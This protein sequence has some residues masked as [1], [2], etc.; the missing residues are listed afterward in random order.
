MKAEAVQAWFWAE[1]RRQ[2]E[3]ESRISHQMV[4]GVD[5]KLRKK[6]RE[7]VIYC[8]T[9]R[10]AC[11]LLTV[12]RFGGDLP[13]WL[14]EAKH[15]RRVAGPTTGCG[16]E[17]ASLLGWPVGDIRYRVGCPH[18]WG[19]LAAKWLLDLLDSGTRTTIPPAAFWHTIDD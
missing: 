5:E 15:R 14:A 6:M 7:L 4:R 16:V 13:K 17:Q 10:D 18:G 19:F 1:M 9:E 12:Y 2:Y 8:P 11:C 3:Q